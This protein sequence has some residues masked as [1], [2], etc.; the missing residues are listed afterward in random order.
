MKKPSPSKKAKSK[1]KRSRSCTARGKARE[2]ARSA[3][4]SR[5][6]NGRDSLHAGSGGAT[7]LAAGGKPRAASGFQPAEIHRIERTGLGRAGIFTG[8]RWRSYIPRTALPL[9]R[10]GRRVCDL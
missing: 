8:S 4:R 7:R 10:S 6:M 1:R 2:R 3:S 5:A 9:P